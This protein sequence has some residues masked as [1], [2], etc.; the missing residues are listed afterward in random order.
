MDYYDNREEFKY[1]GIIDK[2]LVEEELRI[3]RS[4]PMYSRLETKGPKYYPKR[5]EQASTLFWKH[6]NRIVAEKHH[7]I[8]IQSSN[9]W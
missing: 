7:A 9:I 3:L 1:V 6:R 8:Y 2:D 5:G 4:S